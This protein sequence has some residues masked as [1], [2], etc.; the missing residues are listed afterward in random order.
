MKFK[1]GS[2]AARQVTNT[3]GTITI[4][5]KVP[6]GLINTDSNV[7]RTYQ[8]AR[9][10]NGEVELITGT[11]DPTTHMFTFETDK[12][13]T[14]A[15]VY[16]DSTNAAREKNIFFLKYISFKNPSYKIIV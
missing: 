13:S 2:A 8:I 14:Y 1:Q 6:E 4:S 11:Y 12:F 15:I 7:T 5:V 10:H 3:N 9:Y 16:K